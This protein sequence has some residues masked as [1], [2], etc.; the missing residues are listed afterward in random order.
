MDALLTKEAYRSLEALRLISS[1]PAPGGVLLGH[2]R[3][4]RFIVEKVFPCPPAI[5]LSPE[6][7]FELDRLFEGRVIGFF[8]F[9]SSSRKIKSILRPHGFGKLYL[10]ARRDS[11]KKMTLKS[12]VIERD[13]RFIL[14]P[15]SL[16]FDEKGV[17]E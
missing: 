14:V 8:S 13:K 6:I 15:I 1:G 7:F 17:K 10:E 4:H 2:K 3:D 12:F 9:R 5:S 11:R 16:K